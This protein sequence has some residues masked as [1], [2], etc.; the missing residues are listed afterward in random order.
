MNSQIL[1]SISSK[2]GRI[3]FI[4]LVAALIAVNAFAI[5]IMLPGLQQIG[6]GLGEPDENRRQLVIPAYMLGFGI[7]Q[8]FFGPLSDRYGRRMPL[9][10]GLAIYCA[11]ALS[12]YSVGSFDSLVL[13]RFIQGA[14]AAASAVIAMALVRDLYSGDEM[15]K[16]MSLVFMVLML[17]PIL[18][19]GLGQLLLTMVDWPGLFMFMAA[20][21]VLVMTWVWLRLPETLHP[22][23]RRPFTVKSVIE[24][25]GVVF[26]HKVSLA[27][28]IGNGLMFGSLMGFLNSS[29]Q[30][31]VGL[32]GVGKWFPFFFGAGAVFSAIGGFVNSRFVAQYGMRRISNWAAAGFI[33]SAAALLLFSLLLPPAPPLWLFFPLCCI[34]FFTFSMIMPNFGALALEPLGAVAGTAASAQGFLQMVIGAT[35][36]TFIGQIFNG[37]TVPLTAGMLVLSGAAVMLTQWAEAKH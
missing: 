18:A 30:I 32:F 34:T 36:G 12:A 16:T 3:E 1:P 6:A 8:V 9:L 14:G 4:V 24:G 15:A 25:F 28:I 22:E 7:L 21:G 5:D 11:A 26:G 23:Y 10:A 19:P 33:A 27:Y 29:Q 17:S 13:L 2:I 20:L 37:T 35:V 31:Y